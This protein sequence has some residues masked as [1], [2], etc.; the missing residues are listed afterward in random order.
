[1]GLGA[2]V[3]LL[4]LLGTTALCSP[5]DP[6]ADAVRS[7]QSKVDNVRQFIN[8]SP[9]AKTKRYKCVLVDDD[10]DEEEPQVR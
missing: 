2:I 9:P 8:K 1:M 10:D 5:D 3:S 7:Y 4:L 6:L